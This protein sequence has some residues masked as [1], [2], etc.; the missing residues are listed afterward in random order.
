MK[1]LSVKD[2]CLYV[3]GQLIKGSHKFMINDIV[4]HLQ[5]LGPNKLLF[6]RQK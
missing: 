2:I 6:L 5:K 1:P 3:N 4:Y